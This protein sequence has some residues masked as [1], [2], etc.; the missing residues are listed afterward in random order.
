MSPN[1]AIS[2]ARLRGPLM[3]G[4]APGGRVDV[5]EIGTD[6]GI[7]NLVGVANS[8]GL[9]VGMLVGRSTVGSL[10]LEVGM[11][12]GRSTVGS[13]VGP[14]VGSIVG[15]AQSVANVP[16]LDG[17]E[18]RPLGCTGAGGVKTAPFTVVFRLMSAG[19]ASRARVASSTPLHLTLAAMGPSAVGTLAWNLFILLVS[20]LLGAS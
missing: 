16:V 2:L 7:G 20:K 5:G 9:E 8:L 11:L 10:G 12:V 3:F 6:V 17:T 14:V 15:I 4:V 18:V 13:N 19:G 1:T